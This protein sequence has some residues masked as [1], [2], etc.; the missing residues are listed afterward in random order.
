M[1]KAT[2]YKQTRQ[3]DNKLLMD[4]LGAASASRL[5]TS[6][7][8]G[9]SDNASPVDRAVSGLADG[10]SP[11]KQTLNGDTRRPTQL[12]LSPETLENGV[13]FL[14]LGFVDL[15]ENSFHQI[16]LLHNWGI[17]CILNFISAYETLQP[18]NDRKT[19]NEFQKSKYSNI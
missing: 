17:Q 14:Y 8:T 16:S 18:R 10:L 4:F 3:Q 7:A 11:T 13:S 2:R 9:R 15:F 1:E 6:S 5:G 19:I 12:I